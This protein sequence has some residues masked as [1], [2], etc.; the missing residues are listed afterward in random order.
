MALTRRYQPPHGTGPVAY[1]MDFSA[2]IPWG[3]VIA[4]G[5]LTIEVNTQPP[6]AQTSLTASPVYIRGRAIFALLTGG[7][8]GADYL[9]AWSVTDNRGNV[10]NRAA[11]LLCSYTS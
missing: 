2:V 10:W 1:G 4:S 7:V 11:L 8:I 5:N 9:L 3:M 6:T